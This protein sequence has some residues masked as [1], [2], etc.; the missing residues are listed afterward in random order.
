MSIRSVLSFIGLDWNDFISIKDW[1]TEF[2]F[3]FIISNIRDIKIFRMIFIHRGPLHLLKRHHTQQLPLPTG[4]NSQW[5]HTLCCVFNTTF[6]DSA[7]NSL[8]WFCFK[9]RKA[10]ATMR[11]HSSFDHILIHRWTG[12]IVWY[13]LEKFLCSLSRHQ[14]ILQGNTLIQG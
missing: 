8:D 12:I 13:S 2:I 14:C 3:I 9:G 1:S 6:S 11:A 5:S 10:W 4:S 7:T